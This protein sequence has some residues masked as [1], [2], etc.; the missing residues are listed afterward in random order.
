MLGSRAIW[1]KGWKAV[2]THKPT[3]NVGHFEQ[4]EWE[5]YNV[6][7]DRSEIHNL[8][9]QYPEKVEEMRIRWFVEATKCNVLPL[10]D[11][12]TSRMIET[13]KQPTLLENLS[14]YTY[15]P[16]TV[17][18]PEMIAA[19]VKNRSHSIT[20]GGQDSQQWG[21]RNSLTQGSRF[22][23]YSFFVNKNALSTSTTMSD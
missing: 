1:H 21:R 23:G 4:D 22:A 7:V 8:A 18:V 9:K 12:A 15:Y 13:M 10:D 20:R 5:L 11:R 17:E 19:N 14:K 6:D 2:T 16:D 3:S